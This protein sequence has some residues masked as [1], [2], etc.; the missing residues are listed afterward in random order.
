MWKRASE[1][2]VHSTNV[3]YAYTAPT[4]KRA[5]QASI[6][7]CSHFSLTSSTCTHSALAFALFLA[8]QPER[9]LVYSRWVR[10]IK[11]PDQNKTRR[12]LVHTCVWHASLYVLGQGVCVWR[13]V[14]L[15]ST[16]ARRSF[17]HTQAASLTGTT[18]PSWKERL[19]A[20]R[21]S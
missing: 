18:R 19:Q 17:T 15:L 11:S 6:S 2:S 16:F 4:W 14:P 5:S 1:A 8:H 13:L 9:M 20:P 21:T 3:E 12:P 7:L 10:A